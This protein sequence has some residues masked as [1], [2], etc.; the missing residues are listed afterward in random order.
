MNGSTDFDHTDYIEDVPSNA[1]ELALWL[2]SDRMGFLLDTLDQAMLANQQ[3]VVRNERRQSVEN[4]P[5]GLSNEAVHR[6]LFPEGH[7]YYA[8]VIGSHEDIQ[9]AQLRTCATSSGAT[10][11]PTT[12]A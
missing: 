4:A 9:A 12:P 5:Y 11:R 8:S 1:L 7:P 10:T 6:N 3:D 2:E